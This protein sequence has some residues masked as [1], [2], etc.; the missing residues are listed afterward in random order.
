MKDRLG[1]AVRREPMPALLERPAQLDVV[2]DLAVADEN[3][4]SIFV[5]ERLR[6]ARDVD[7]AQAAHRQS[8]V[9][10]CGLAGAVWAPVRERRA[11][12][13]YCVAI[14]R[15][16]ASSSDDSRDPAHG[17]PF[18]DAVSI[19]LG[20]VRSKLRAY[21]SSCDPRPEAASRALHSGTAR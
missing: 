10:A 20:R 12:C 9:V 2:V 18:N 5:V 14:V 13:A 19:F 16:Q 15:R 3:E 7:D 17:S 21:G 4:R 6:A 11:H 8:E 1:I